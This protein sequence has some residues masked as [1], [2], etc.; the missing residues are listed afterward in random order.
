MGTAAD[1]VE[2]VRSLLEQVVTVGEPRSNGPLTLVPLFGALPAGPY[3]I[4]TTAV[5]L[6]PG[7]R[8]RLPV[9]C[10]ERGRWG[11]RER[12]DF[13]PSAGVA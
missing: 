5:L 4:V 9:A 7:A 1:A 3:R 2:R 6:A 8:T 12:P 10:V 13:E 11:Y